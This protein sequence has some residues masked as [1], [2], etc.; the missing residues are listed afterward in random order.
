MDFD[1]MPAQFHRLPH[2]EQA[3]TEAVSACR[4]D[5]L[6]SVDDARELFLC[7]GD[8][9]VADFDANFVDK[10]LAADHD[11]SEIS[12][13]LDGVANA[14]PSSTAW[15]SLVHCKFAQR[16]SKPKLA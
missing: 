7:Q 14:I 5:P 2:N 16:W 10:S 13:V 3:D 1:A 11:S 12:I 9:G 4:V 8:T 6:E 15:K